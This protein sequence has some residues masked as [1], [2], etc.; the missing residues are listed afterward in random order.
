MLKQ[1]RDMEL[2]AMAHYKAELGL[3]LVDPLVLRI[4]DF[5]LMDSAINEPKPTTYVR[6]ING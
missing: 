2:L 6:K 4:H 1:D 5:Y 3:V